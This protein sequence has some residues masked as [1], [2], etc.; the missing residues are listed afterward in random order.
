[1]RMDTTVINALSAE[2]RGTRR[3]ARAMRGLVAVLAVLMVWQ[4]VSS[5]HAPAVL[6]ER[7]VEWNQFDVGIKLLTDGKLSITETQVI[8]FQDGP[9]TAGSRDIP[10]GK[11]DG[12]SNVQVA[13]ISGNQK[14]PFQEVDRFDREP[15]TYSV[16]RS[17]SELVINWGFSPTTDAT[18]TFEITYLVEGGVRNYPDETPPN[19]QIWWTAISSDLT[20]TAPVN[21]STTSITLPSAVDPADVVVGT[22]NL[23][24]EP[25]TS[26]NKTWTWKATDL[27]GGDD[28]T[29]RIQFPPMVNIATPSW[30]ARDDQQR[31]QAEESDQRNAIYN[32]GFLVLGGLGAIVGGM[33]LYGLW[34][35]KGRDPQFGPVAAFL[36]TPPGDLPPGAVGVLLDE[37]ADQR[38]V[39]ATLADLGNRGV[40]DM[41]E[42]RKEGIFGL[43]GGSDYEIELKQVPENLRPFEKT[44]LE[45]LFGSGLDAGKRVKMSDVGSSFRESSDRIKD[46]LYDE[47]MERKFFLAQPD[48]TRSH[49]RSMGIGALI[50]SVLLGCVGISFFSTRAP[51]VWIPV[52][53]LFV[54]SI[55]LIVMS[56]RMP[57]KT[58]K[59]AEEA[60]K[61][62][63]FRTYLADIDKYEDIGAKN[64]IFQKYLPYAIAFGLEEDYTKKF[65]EAGSPTPTWFD[66]VP[67]EM[68]Y[69]GGRGHRGPRMGPVVIWGGSPF[70]G[71]SDWGGSGQGC[72]GGRGGIDVP[73]LQD[74]SDSTASTLSRSSNSLFGMLGAA[75]A[76]F[77]AASMS[78]KGGGSFG[79]GGG[80]GGGFSGGGGFGGGGGSGGGGG[81]FS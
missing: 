30:Q 51:L 33:A 27:R 20:N 67:G 58:Q 32:L 17:A 44:L 75:A 68:G 12:I 69:P 31:A 65:A 9:F 57:K 47:V 35:T 43:G 4:L 48:T 3:T 5:L 42:T 54:L 18:R 59:G 74:M 55:V 46:Q 78:G 22:E 76:A 16:T 23:P 52:V 56:S 34:Y 8:D 13:E 60:A 19:Q 25:T 6:A 66:P 64:E 14:T 15:G 11:V 37:T 26:D 61:Y 21:E 45:S 70:G 10:L 63:A 53:V 72:T 50:L 39:V 77:G 36:S 40:I 62:R 38:D 41:H 7:S 2:P 71:S 81:G 73:D 80:F 1:M 79:G 29:V 24:I 49:Y 28:L